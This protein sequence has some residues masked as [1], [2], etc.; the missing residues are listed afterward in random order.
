MPVDRQREYETIVIIRPDAAEDEFQEVRDRVDDVVDS[1]GGHM[2]QTD[3]WGRRTLAYE[4]KDST[5][6]R[7]F[8]RG[9]YHYYRYIGP[10]GTVA[11]LERN[12]KLLDSVLKF[13]TVKID[14]DL[15]PDQ[16]LAQPEEEEI[17]VP[18]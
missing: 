8:E 4:I 5:E 6:G 11:E 1:E 9:V 12:L 7:Q 13:L 10:S 14:D 16:R 2:L 15:I 17:V 18:D 3:D